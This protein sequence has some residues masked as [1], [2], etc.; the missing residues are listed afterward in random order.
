[1]D[2]TRE[3]RIEKIFNPK[4]IAIVGASRNK[5][6][7]G[8]GIAKNLLEGGTFKSKYCTPFNGRVYL[9]NPKADKILGKKCYSDLSS[10]KNKIDLVIIVVPAIIVEHIVK[11]CVKLNIGGII[12]ISAG[13]AEI[14]KQGKDLQ[15]KV[16]LIAKKAGIPIVGPNCLGIIRPSIGMNAS[17]AP[18][19]PPKGNVAFISQSGALADSII[20]WAIEARYGFSTIASI[21]N[22]VDLD[23]H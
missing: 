16:A 21:G 1:M 13:F 17:F 9:V 3:K 11:E 2:K 10:I 8:Y 14:G 6:S 5:K 23:H 18:S 12:I 7:V 4:S 15:N 22:Q 20:D 19:M